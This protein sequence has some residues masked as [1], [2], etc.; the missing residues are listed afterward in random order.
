MLSGWPTGRGAGGYGGRGF[1]TR[2]WW[3]APLACGGAYW[4]LAFEPS[5]MTRGGGGMRAKKKFVDPK[6]ASHFIWFSV[7]S[8]TFSRGKIFWLWVGG[9]FGLRAGPARPPPPANHQGLV[10]TPPPPVD[11]HPMTGSVVRL[12]K[13]T[14]SRTDC[15]RTKSVKKA[16]LGPFLW[17]LPV[18][19]RFE[20][21]QMGQWT[22]QRKQSW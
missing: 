20:A 14:G 4:P 5:A 17:F 16:I 19:G 13:C 12:T 9:R 3:L 2:P 7:Q 11:K 18:F 1:G 8:F 22:P 21:W 15:P 6:W 10:P